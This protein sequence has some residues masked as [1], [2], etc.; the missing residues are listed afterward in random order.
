MNDFQEI[1]KSSMNHLTAFT[2]DASTVLD[3]VKH[4]KRVARRRRQMLSSAV[5]TC[6]LLLVC[7]FGTVKAASYMKN[8][9]W[10]TETG[11][12]SRDTK[13]LEQARMA[14]GMTAEEYAESSAA[15]ALTGEELETEAISGAEAMPMQE[16]LQTQE[17][18]KEEVMAADSAEDSGFREYD[19]LAE[20][21]T[22]ETAAIAMPEIEGETESIRIFASISGEDVILLQHMKDGKMVQVRSVSYADSVGHSSATV[23]GDTVANGREYTTAAGYTYQLIDT[24]DEKEQSSGVHAAITVGNYEVFADFWGYSQEQALKMIESMDLSVYGKE[25]ED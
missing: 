2:I 15:Q 16:M 11:F 9:I 19:N 17:A 13:T 8:V 4:R 22:N 21:E 12:A 10:V 3:E 5:V 23:Y 20:F 6:S 18:A 25:Q 24:I 1:Y 14:E 7:G